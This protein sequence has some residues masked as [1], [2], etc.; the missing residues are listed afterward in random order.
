M[1]KKFLVLALLPMLLAG[2]DFEPDSLDKELKSTVVMAGLTQGYAQEFTLK[3]DMLAEPSDVY[4]KNL[5][6][7]AFGAAAANTSREAIT[8][9]YRDMM[10]SSLE[11]SYTYDIPPSKDT[12][13]YAIGSRSL[14]HEKVVLVSVRGFN[15]GGEWNSNLHLGLQGDHAGFLEAATT[16]LDDLD[17]YI[18][19]YRHENSKFIFTGYSRGGAVANLAAKLLFEREDKLIN[20]ENCYFYTFEAA[21]A[22]A[23]YHDYKNVF[24]FI[25]KKDLVPM[26]APEEYGFYRVGQDIYIDQG[27][28]DEICLNYDESIVFPQFKEFEINDVVVTEDTMPQTMIDVLRTDSFGEQN[29]DT[30]EKFVNVCEETLGYFMTLFMSL[31]SSTTDQLLADLTS[32]S[33]FE[34]LSIIGDGESFSNFLKPYLDQAG[35]VYDEA[36]LLMYSTKLTTFITQGPGMLLLVVYGLYGDSFSRMIR[37]HSPEVSYALLEVL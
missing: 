13:A 33:I 21:K 24:N 36:E 19:T 25:I 23:E 35:F 31:P 10:F 17:D 26:I 32:K 30:R 15:Y 22:C 9:Y 5:A 1:K 6:L 18:Q 29:V 2:C 7:F 11:L 37:M 16:L 14:K 34:I 3:S 28:V 27:N 4:N 12:I 8:K 20:D